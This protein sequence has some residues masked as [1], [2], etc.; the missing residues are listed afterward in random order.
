[1]ERSFHVHV[2]GTS[3][4]RYTSHRRDGVGRELYWQGLGRE[5]TMIREFSSRCKRARVVFDIGANSGLFTLLACAVNSQ[6]KVVAFEPAPEVRRQLQSLVRENG[7]EDRCIVRPEAASNVNGNAL[8][9]IPNESW[10]SSSLN[11]AGFHGLAGTP[12]EVRTA[13]VDSIASDYP[14]VDLM[15]IDVEGFEDVVLEGA[16]ETVARCVPA[17]I[18]E[19]NPD[20]PAAALNA[21]LRRNRYACFLLAEQRTQVESIDPVKSGKFHNWLC[22]PRE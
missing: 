4:F 3:G 19:C 1:M 18:L 2:P 20:G 10:T 11:P 6:T 7:F 15:K 12:V 8:L 9:H 16:R 21:F 13:T 14:S 17:I 22:L 5:A